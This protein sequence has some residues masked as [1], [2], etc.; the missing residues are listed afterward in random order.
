MNI[1][2]LVLLIA[3]FFSSFVPVGAQSLSNL[4]TSDR[5]SIESA[6]STSK[7]VEGPAA[8]HQCL[9][10]QL[11]QLGTSQAPN[12]TDLS[13]SDR[14]SI[15]SACSTSKYVEGPAAYHQCLSRQLA[16]LGTSQAPNLANLSTSDRSSIE[17]ACSTSKYVEGAAAYHAC[18]KRQ[19]RDLS[20]AE[21]LPSAR[22]HS[23]IASANVVPVQRPE[24]SVPVVAPISSNS[25]I[26]SRIGSTVVLP[27]PTGSCAENGSCYGDISD[28]TGLPKTVAVQ[29]YYRADGTY[30]RGYYRSHK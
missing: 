29:G 20:L 17:S 19:I 3:S 18:L 4:S 30:V 22:H 13:T 12:L 9:S 8:Y 27:V 7:Y 11:A 24:A 16:Q 21:T 15:E 5:F 1:K 23:A 10:G 25:A 28:K 2:F 6:C 14:F 26:T